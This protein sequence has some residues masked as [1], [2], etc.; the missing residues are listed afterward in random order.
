MTEEQKLDTALRQL[1]NT[2][3]WWGVDNH[4]GHR[5]EQTLRLS[6]DGATNLVT[7]ITKMSAEIDK[8][9]QERTAQ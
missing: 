6:A 8:L 3:R 4:L 5:T 9:N 2:L 1:D 7:L